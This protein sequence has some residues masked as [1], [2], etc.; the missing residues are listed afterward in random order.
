MITPLFIDTILVDLFHNGIFQLSANLFTHLDIRRQICEQKLEG[1]SLKISPPFW[2]LFDEEDN[3][4]NYVVNI[5]TAGGVDKWFPEYY[6]N[7]V[8]PSVRVF[9]E[10]L[11]ATIKLRN[12]QI[13]DK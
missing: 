4:E 8:Y 12:T 5:D 3:I 2:S 1:Y 7:E 9:S 11:S 13:H 6:V 10:T